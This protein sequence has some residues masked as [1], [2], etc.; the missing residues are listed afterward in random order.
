MKGKQDSTPRSQGPVT[1]LHQFVST[2]LLSHNF[3]NPCLSLVVSFAS[4][5]SDYIFQAFGLRG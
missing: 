2:T 4:S 3:K 5:C 1:A